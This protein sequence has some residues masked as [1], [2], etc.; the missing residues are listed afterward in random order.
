[1]SHI[2][3]GAPERLRLI[4]SRIKR[5]ENL[6]IPPYHLPADWQLEA[7][8]QAIILDLESVIADHERFVFMHSM[9]GMDYDQQEKLGEAMNI[10]PDD[11]ARLPTLD[12]FRSAIDAAK[13]VV[14][15]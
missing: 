12:E 13:K 9:V 10:F 1:M 15:T 6:R 3:N 14:L 2:E 5:I 8:A 7:I 4:V 11:D